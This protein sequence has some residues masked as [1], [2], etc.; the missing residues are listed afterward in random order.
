MSRRALLLAVRDALQ[1]DVPFQA[2]ECDLTLP[3]GQPPPACGKWFAG[4]W[5]GG[6][7]CQSRVSL[8]QVFDLTV[9][10]TMRIE[11]PFDR[12]RERLV[13]QTLGFHDLAEK[14]ADI[15]HK[16]SWTHHI[17]YRANRYLQDLYAGEEPL[18][19]REGLGMLNDVVPRI[20]GGN[21]FHAQTEAQEVGLV[22]D[23]NF[24]YARR[25][26]VMSNLPGELDG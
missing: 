8:D 23:V 2:H 3:G 19:F 17:Q 4:I 24:G 10:L 18:G 12:I 9:T 6:S 5:A 13:E 11:E 1:E 20:V 14:I 25:I 26:K 21:W 16:D 22:Q 7:R 15:V